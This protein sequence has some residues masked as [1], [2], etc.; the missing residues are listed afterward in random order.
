MN[1]IIFIL[2]LVLISATCFNEI[3]MK[4]R[5]RTPLETKMFLAYMNRE[6]LIENVAKIIG[7]LFLGKNLNLY[8]YPEVKITNYLDAQYYGYISFFI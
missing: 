2:G 3:S 6:P 7:N 1:K 8:S 5:Q 4:H